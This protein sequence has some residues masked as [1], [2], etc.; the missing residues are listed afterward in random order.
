MNKSDEKKISDEKKEEK[1]KE[2]E[3]KL[4]NKF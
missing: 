3:A 1:V 2:S 4:D